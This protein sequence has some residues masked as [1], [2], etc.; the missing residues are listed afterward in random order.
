MR[1][2]ALWNQSHKGIGD[3]ADSTEAHEKKK[4]A[5]LQKEKN[6]EEWNQGVISMIF[7]LEIAEDLIILNFNSWKLKKISSLGFRRSALKSCYFHLLDVSLV[8]LPLR[9]VW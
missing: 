9:F 1:S 5:G 2:L 3:Q 4:Q 6:R 8:N 7:K